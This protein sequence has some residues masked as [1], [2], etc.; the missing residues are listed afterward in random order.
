M[1]KLVDYLVN[2]IRSIVEM[3]LHTR[4][5]WRSERFEAVVDDSTIALIASS[6]SAVFLDEN[7]RRH[8][9]VFGD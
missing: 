3:C 4:P 1:V 6:V 7:I 2:P 5:H 9:V 8:K